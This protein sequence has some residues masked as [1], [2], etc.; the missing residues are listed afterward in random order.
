MEEII[1][2]H[3]L[4]NAVQFNGKANPGAVI[5]K[6]LQED[7]KLKLKIGEISKK[8]NETVKK[9]TE[10]YESLNFNTAI[11]QMMI[12]VNAVYK[13]DVFPLEYAKGLL[14][15][16]N[17]ITPFVTE[18]LWGI[19]TGANKSM[20]YEEWPTFDG[21]KL[22]EHTFELIIQINGKLKGKVNASKGMSEKALTNLALNEENIKKL[23]ENSDIIKIIVVP[24]RLINIVIK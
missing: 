22:I 12:F 13:E 18:E 11:S 7:P 14:K 16:L 4:N 2:K 8:V 21:N 15:L 23:T 10:D 19:V 3:A 5:G 1:L 9:V 20:A 17:P 6:I 24:D